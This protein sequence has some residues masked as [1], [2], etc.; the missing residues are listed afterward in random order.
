[1]FFQSFF[2][3]H[4]VRIDDHFWVIN[5][6]LFSWNLVLYFDRIPLWGKFVATILVGIL[7]G[8]IVM[9]IVKPRLRKSIEG[10]QEI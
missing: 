5:D 2:L 9:I 1:M 8:L 7:V 6:A 10:R 4:H 3:L